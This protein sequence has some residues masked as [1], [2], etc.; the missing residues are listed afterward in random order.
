MSPA[1]LIT[2]LAGLGL[3]PAD[4]SQ[5]AAQVPPELRSAETLAAR[6]EAAEW[7]PLEA[8]GLDAELD[9]ATVEAELEK[10]AAYLESHPRD[11][12]ALLLTVRLGRIRD[13][14]AFQEAYMDLFEDPSAGEPRVPSHARHLEVLDG[15]LARDS[16]VAAAHYWRARLLLEEE[17]RQAGVLTQI[18]P[19]PATPQEVEARALEHARAAVSYDL[20]NEV[21]REFLALLLA[22]GGDVGGASAVLE[23]PTTAG[24][25]LHLLVQDLLVFAPP[26]SAEEDQAMSTFML[27]L[28]TMGAADLE[29]PELALFLELRA[30]GWSAPVDMAEVQAY[31]R[32]RWPG[33]RFFPAGELDGAVAAAFVV[34]DARWRAVETEE[35]YETADRAS[36]GHVM[37]LLLPPSAYDEMRKMSAMQGMP[38]EAVLPGERVG[39]LFLDTRLG[40]AG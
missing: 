16:T 37:L 40:P 30:Q 29:A 24:G 23:H 5:A 13:L 20:G 31:Y 27:M 21:H 1:A 10:V 17:A 25:L 22:V 28:A 12:G 18:L 3:L 8:A 14:L 32:E 39:I 15:I 2:V 33:L 19:V 38:P 35:D 11:T 36:T 9:L 6:V 34:E 7:S 4:L 26:P